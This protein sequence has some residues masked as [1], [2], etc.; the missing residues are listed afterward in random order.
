M[1]HQPVPETSQALSFGTFRLFKTQRQ[2][3]DRG[4]PVRLGSR[5]LDLLIALVDRPGEVISRRDLE[6]LVWPRT[7]VEETSLRAHI[8]A[9]RKALGDGLEGARYITNIPGRGYCFVAAVSK[10][11]DLP[12]I[13]VSSSATGPLPSLPFTRTRLIGRD[14]ALQSVAAMLAKRRLVTVTGPGGMGKTTTALAVADE[15]ALNYRDGVRFVDFTPVTDPTLLASTVALALGV[16]G[17]SPDLPTARTA[18]AAYL[19]DSHM[20]LVLDNCEHVIEAAAALVEMLLTATTELAILITSR[21]PLNVAD[22]WVYRLAS[23]QLPPASGPLNAAQAL[24]SAA[25]QLFVQRASAASESFVLTDDLAPVLRDVCWRLDGIP[26][27]IELAAARID[28]LRLEGLA[29]RIDEHLL[30]LTRGRRTAIPRHRTLRALVDWSYALLSP[31][32]QTVLRRLA[33]F[34]AG[35]TLESATALAATE[36]DDRAATA[37]VVLNLAAKSL[38]AIETIEACAHDVRYRMLET[39]RAFAMERLQQSD[40]HR[41]VFHRYALQMLAQLANCESDWDRM[42]RNLWVGTYAHLMDDIRA[43]LDW[44]FLPD[45]DLTIGVALTATAVGLVRELGQLDGYHK[46]VE[47]ALAHIHLL[48]TPQPLMELQLNAASCFNSGHSARPQSVEAGFLKRT[49]EL[50]EQ[51]G[52]PRYQI[53]AFY[54]TWV[55]TFGTGNYLAANAAA[56]Q[57]RD[58]GE[59][60]QDRFAMLLGDRLCAQALHF[61]GEYDASTRLAHEVLRH[62]DVQ[63]PVIYASPVSR[64]VSMGI[65]LS[66]TL[67][68][69]GVADQAASMAAA[70]VGRAAQE[71]PIAH[72]QAIGIAACPIAFWSGN[73]AEA[74]SWATRLQDLARCHAST[75]WAA[76]A[77]SYLAVVALGDA[78]A[79]PDA[80]ATLSPLETQHTKVLDCMGTLGGA[81][82]SRATLARA[83]NGLA[84]WCAP[85]ILRVHG[86]RLWQDR[87]QTS[88]ALA[89]AVFEQSLALAQQQGALAWEL[90]TACSLARL[91]RSQGRL[92]AARDLVGATF[93][94]FNEGFATAD[95]RAAHQLLTAYN[96]ELDLNTRLHA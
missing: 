15:L 58:L 55:G 29:S 46:R 62:N 87:A 49:L 91:W 83:Q 21:E 32:E 5:A 67:W 37:E 9:L 10:E 39:T 72:M 36:A 45:G 27:A 48:P 34:K 59:R 23:L 20:L 52:Q 35:F 95:L 74:E 69:Q 96:A 79:C 63:L 64:P 71:H 1:L 26:L 43:A 3:L 84:G 11:A 77:Q 13:G 47:I 14:E 17:T 54:S 86:E 93:S 78:W 53:A 4:R 40:E 25:A 89:E 80:T 82:F 2:L 81:F 41:A 75:Y 76:W 94:R 24:E 31:F 12:A 22:E 33:V 65:V 8:S 19:A 50:A 60:M 51:L 73:I 85:E 70:C 44:C 66:R 30:L 16:S 6:S 28:A 68:L 18:L 56:H 7:I 90:R 92:E 61:M 88:A 42:S 38:V 57:V